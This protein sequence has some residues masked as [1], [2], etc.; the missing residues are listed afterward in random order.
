MKVLNGKKGLILVALLMASLLG[1]YAAQYYTWNATYKIIPLT[2]DDLSISVGT[3]TGATMIKTTTYDAKD[4]TVP[5]GKKLD[6]YFFVKDSDVAK[7][8]GHFVL[9][10]FKY[11]S[12][13]GKVDLTDDLNTGGVVEGNTGWSGSWVHAEVDNSGGSTNLVLDMKIDISGW[14][15]NVA[16][17][18]G[19]VTFSVWVWAQEF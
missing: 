11:Y 2:S 19:E 13:D 6:I 18:S 3:H 9:L 7:I 16:S 5:A 8:A 4:I 1:A 12:T 14:T 17:E 10:K 15:A